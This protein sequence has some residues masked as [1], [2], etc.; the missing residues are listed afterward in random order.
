MSGCQTEV[1][2]LGERSVG[3][4]GTR[5]EV[6]VAIKGQLGTSLVVQWLRFLTLNAGGLGLIPGQGTRSHITQLKISHVATN[7]RCSQT[8]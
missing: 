5:K 1:R 3:R 4:G 7:I 2:D 6:G 8:D